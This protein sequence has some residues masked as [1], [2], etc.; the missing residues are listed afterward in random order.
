MNIYR[1]V[2]QMVL[3]ASMLIAIDLVSIDARADT[4]TANACA[5]T[6]SP[7]ARLIYDKTFPQLKPNSNLRDLLTNN[8]RT[9]VIRGSISRT[10]A[11][12]SAT[13]ASRCL[14]KAR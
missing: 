8:T 7:D 5:A 12:A 10:K 4:A 11:R 2:S 9:L 3:V 6:L 1:T 14:Q 13:D